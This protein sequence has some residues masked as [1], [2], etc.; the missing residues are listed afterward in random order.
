METPN[1][2]CDLVGVLEPG[3]EGQRC[4]NGNTTYELEDSLLSPSNGM[5]PYTSVCMYS[6]RL[7]NT[8]S[9]V[10]S[11]YYQTCRCISAELLVILFQLSHTAV[12]QTHTSASK[13]SIAIRLYMGAQLFNSLP[14]E[15]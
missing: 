4:G 7:T 12:I 14:E 1:S 6:L 9:L 8:L 3:R 11:C 13:T 15:I 10:W 5:V 2:R